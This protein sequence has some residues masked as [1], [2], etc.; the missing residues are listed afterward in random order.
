MII[1][2]K[3]LK[4]Q[5][6]KIEVG[7]TESVRTFKEKIEAHKGNEFPANCQKLIYAGKIL[8]DDTKIRDY[9]IDEKK[10]VVIMVTKPQ[11]SQ[12]ESS[13]S[14]ASQ[15][16]TKT[17]NQMPSKP[18]TSKESTEP[19]AEVKPTTSPAE[20]ESKPKSEKPVE[21]SSVTSVN[22]DISAA[23]STLVLGE[24]YEKMVSQ[25]TEMGYE[26]DEVERALRASFNNP[27]RAVEYL[28]TGVL[29]P[30]NEP[31][32]DSSPVAAVQS[33]NAI[34]IP[35][36]S[37]EPLAFL[38]SQPQF[39]QM[40]QVIQQNPQLLNAV[41]QQ[42]GQNN[43]QLLLLISQNQEAFVRMLNEPSSGTG[44]G[45]NSTPVSTRSVAAGGSIPT[46]PASALSGSLSSASVESPLG[47][48]A[49]QMSPQDREAID[50]LKALGFPEYLVVQA[51]FACDK[52]ENLAANFLLSQNFDE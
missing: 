6:F 16:Q 40:R 44:Q 2:L 39:Q 9:D 49:T 10:F 42:I 36:A 21:D 15:A 38:R 14:S 24:D 29:P 8:S 7:E 3:T 46:V 43:P 17:V 26:R 48:A 20:T 11:T 19:S 13:E 23:E 1:T 51:Y 33:T 5:T 31:Q 27:D 37:D 18:E 4:Q 52:N 25:I 22:V 30:E 32:A 47:E 12:E 28:I 45:G 35:I 41:L 34:P 50:R